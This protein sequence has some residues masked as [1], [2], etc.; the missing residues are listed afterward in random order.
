V[1]CSCADWLEDFVQHTSYGESRAEMMWWVGVSTIAG[2]LRRK[3][4]IEEFNFQW[5]PNFFILLIGPP[6]IVKK[7]TSSGLGMRLLH[8]VDGIDFGP[9]ASTW[10]QLVT[11]MAGAQKEYKLPN[12]NIFLASCV[13]LE[14]S[15]FGTFFDPDNRNMVDGM[16]DL[17]DAKLHTFRKETKTNGCDEVVNPWLNMIAGCTQGWIDDNFSSKFIRSGFASRVVYVDCGKTK[18]IAYPS[19]KMPRG[20]MWE[21][22]NDLVMRLMEIAELSGEM[23]LTEEAY[24][25]GERW[26][27]NYRDFLDRC[28]EDEIGLYSRA[29]THLHKLAMI[30]SAA[31][32]RFPIIDVAELVEADKRLA[33]L[34]GNISKV[35]G[36]VGQSPTS[37][38]AKD[39]I[40]ILTKNGKMTKREL[41]AKFFFR[42]VSATSFDEALKNAKAGGYL[43]EVGDL[44]NPILELQ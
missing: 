24:Q 14:L 28:S 15:E 7:S 25:W 4:W 5:T 27:E 39:V 31:R 37:K 8:R 10:E 26:Y 9:Q 3:V 16:T 19:R 38:L 32:G 35:F 43:K 44:T 40:E 11:H 36:R 13:T 18:R 23:R 2:A 29:Q 30:V 22:E 33:E 12:G 6:G 17:W 1:S 41:F 34:G 21:R 20:T 42:T